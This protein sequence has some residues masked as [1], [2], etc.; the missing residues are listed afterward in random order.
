MIFQKQKLCVEI[1][2]SNLSSK[3]F[4]SSLIKNFYIKSLDKDKALQFLLDL[5]DEIYNSPELKFQLADIFF[6]NKNN[7][8]EAVSL[9]ANILNELINKFNYPEARVKLFHLYLDQNRVDLA[10]EELDVIKEQ[11][12]I[13]ELYK[14][15]LEA[16][17]YLKSFNFEKAYNKLRTICKNENATVHS[18]KLLAES[19][20]FNS[21][22][23]EE[24]KFLEKATT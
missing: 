9:C 13:T 11:E 6:M 18:Y 23:I 4:A 2:N 17:L 5:N 22:E 20:Q 3:L 16:E 10:S 8:P 7:Y 14:Q 19:A 21:D 24:I 15:E 12:K 1:L